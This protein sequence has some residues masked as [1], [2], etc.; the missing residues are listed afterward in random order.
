MARLISTIWTNAGVPSSMRVPPEEGAAMSGSR[1]AV[2]QD[3][4]G[5]ARGGRRPDRAAEEAELAHDQRSRIT[6]VPRPASEHGLVGASRNA[7]RSSSAR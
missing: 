4:G 3:G 5:D 7:A 1:S 6:P 2:A